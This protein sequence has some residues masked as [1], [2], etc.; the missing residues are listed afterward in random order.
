MKKIVSV[1]I[2][3]FFLTLPAISFGASGWYGSVNAGLGIVSDSDID[4]TI[5]GLGSGSGKL[6]Y[7][8][9]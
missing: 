3:C 6:S 4:V 1:L 5:T 2:G 9:G 8:T 7:D